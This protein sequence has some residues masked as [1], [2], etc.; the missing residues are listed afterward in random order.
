MDALIAAVDLAN[1]GTVVIGRAK[2]GSRYRVSLLYGERQLRSTLVG[3]AEELGELLDRSMPGEVTLRCC[4][5]CGEVYGA[6]AGGK[7]GMPFSHGYCS[8]AC[9]GLLPDEPT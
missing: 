2:H 4:L 1:D 9:A 5:A 6:Y 3:T 8:T 7:P